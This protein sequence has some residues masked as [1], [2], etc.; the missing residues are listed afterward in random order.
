MKPFSLGEFDIYWLEGGRFQIDGGSMFGVVP[1]V[2][3]QKR[4]P[5]DGDNYCDLAD[6]VILVRTPEANII[7]ETGLGDKLT[8]KQQKI[9]RLQQPWTIPASLATLGL[10]CDDISHVILTHGDFDHAGGVT[11][12][13]ED[14]QPCLSFP[15]ANYYLQRQEWQDI[16]QPNRR[17]ASTYW[18]QNFAGLVEGENLILVD[19]EQELLPGVRV[20]L[21]GGHTRGHQV[22]WL[23][24]EEQQ[25]AH[26]GDL[27]P[28][29]AYANP[30][31][32]TAY[33]NFPLDSIAAKER[34]LAQVE[35]QDAWL[36]FYHDPHTLACKFNDKGE[37][38]QAWSATD[39]QRELG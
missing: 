17:S 2:L 22:V 30:L 5:C 15:K 31:W 33:D 29:T 1:K 27:L 25:A 11:R 8:D 23:Q 4:W 28:N 6:S 24:S 7:I 36:L 38:A 32:I 13:G 9:F 18:P 14:G 10:S 26:L 20:E 35:E 19:G 3:W 12:T 16:C 39:A 34:L 21:T 37:V